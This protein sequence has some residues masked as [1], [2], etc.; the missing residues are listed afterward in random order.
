MNIFV[1][2]NYMVRK[3]TMNDNF[4]N[5]LITW[6]LYNKR[7]LPWRE[8]TNP[9]FIWI[10]EVI[11]Q[12]TRV[13]QGLPYYEK[14]IDEFP[15]INLLAASS[16]EK[17]LKLWQ[18]LGYYSRARNMHTAAKQVMAEFN[19]QFPNNYTEL[20][21]L[22]GVGEYTAAAVASL[23]FNEPVAVVDGNVIRV[24]SRYFGIT[25]PIDKP[26]VLKKIKSLAQ[27]LLLKEKPALYNQAIMEFGALQCVPANPQCG[28]CP[29]FWH[30]QALKDKMVNQI[31]AKQSKTKVRERFFYYLIIKEGKNVFLNKRPSGDIWEGLYDFPLIETEKQ[32]ELHELMKNH[33]W[34]LFFGDKS[35]HIKQISSL[36]K[37]ILSH[38]RLNVHFINIEAGNLLT[39]YPDNWIRINADTIH[40]IAVPRLIDRYIHSN[41]FNKLF[42]DCT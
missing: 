37:H 35:I 2:K 34:Q 7:E 13:A 23:A 12:Q 24:I 38:Q 5:A 6:Y 4:V 39:N 26:V 1:S 29:V 36:V 20:L 16:E 3:H 28:N 33:S 11:L 40:G 14:I 18:G 15:T 32:I 30:C 21:L 9:Y 25:E 10:S 8:T 31:P 22:K 17:I 27:E 42:A 41:D 19:G